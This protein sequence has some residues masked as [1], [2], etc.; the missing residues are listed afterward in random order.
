M[1]YQEEVT[2]RIADLD[3]EVCTVEDGWVSWHDAVMG[4]TE[5]TVGQKRQRCKDWISRKT[6]NLVR[7]RRRAKLVRDQVG[8]RSRHER[9]RSLDRQVKSSAREDKQKWLDSMGAD[10][11]RAARSGEHRRM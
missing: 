5:A 3:M 8:S 4:T 7:E 9:Y 11:E 2:K 1:A 10:M 6:E